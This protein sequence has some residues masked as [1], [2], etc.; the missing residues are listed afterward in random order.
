MAL[1]SQ[2][3]TLKEN[4][5][6]YCHLQACSSAFPP[7][8]SHVH[9]KEAQLSEHRALAIFL[10]VTSTHGNIHLCTLC[11]RHPAGDLSCIS[12]LWTAASRASGTGTNLGGFHGQCAWGGSLSPGQ[13][14]CATTTVF[15]EGK[16][17]S[18]LFGTSSAATVCHW[19]LYLH[20]IFKTTL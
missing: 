16:S 20:P 13:C 6:R 3:S 15:P 5:I 17:C 9:P 11:H 4:L 14:V 2:S 8:R 1:H 19:K 10:P 18:N 7:Q 12:P